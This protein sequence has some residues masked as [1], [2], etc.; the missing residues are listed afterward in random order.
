[1]KNFIKKLIVAIMISTTMIVSCLGSFISFSASANTITPLPNSALQYN[2]VI[3]EISRTGNKAKVELIIHV[4]NNPGTNV[5]QFQIK[6]PEGCEFTSFDPNMKGLP[7][8]MDAS[9]FLP[10]SA[11]FS[12][13][14]LKATHDDFDLGVF[15]TIEDIK[16]SNEFILT[17]AGYRSTEENIDSLETKP[18]PETIP[19]G[20]DKQ[21]AILLG[22]ANDNSAIDTNDAYFTLW[23]CTHYSPVDKIIS[24]DYL[25][26]QRGTA[27]YQENLPNLKYAEIIDVDFDGDIDET[28][29][30]AIEMY[31]SKWAMNQSV[32]DLAI[33]KIYYIT[34][35]D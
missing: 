14:T 1:M 21:I 19:V 12:Y 25:N 13:L 4:T 7:N 26:S 8:S 6:A 34:V 32:D 16:K 17:L 22:D 10:N 35:K 30:Y 31:Y 15:A 18:E 9:T 27:V 3:Q 2:F 24:V 23:A 11:F 20:G 33:G 29:A 28:D 5:I